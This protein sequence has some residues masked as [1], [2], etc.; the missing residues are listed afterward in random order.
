[1]VI[2]GIQRIHLLVFAVA[3]SSTLAFAQKVNVDYD[4]S[5]DFS[6]YKSYTLERPVAQPAKPLLY[7]QVVGS[8][9]SELEAKGL[10]RKDTDGDLTLI[11][12]GGL[13][14]GLGGLPTTDD[15][16]KNCQAPL[17]DPMEWPGRSGPPGVGGKPQ[18]NGNLQMSFVDPLAKKTV[19]SGTVTQKLDPDKKEK[20]L[21]KANEAV[22]K[23]LANFPPSKK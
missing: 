22:K 12:S 5:V 18:P 9:Q 17:R 23:L 4:K 10:I 11:L 2:P 21:K 7:A 1:M 14:Y 19:W 16:C 6:R 15:S 13:D 20:S 3:V 8:I